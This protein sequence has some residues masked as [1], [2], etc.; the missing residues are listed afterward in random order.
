[1]FLTATKAS[2]STVRSSTPKT[3]KTKTE[4]VVID[5]CNSCDD[6]SQTSQIY[7]LT[8]P[9]KEASPA[10]RDDAEPILIDSRSPSPK[11]KKT[12]SQVRIEMRSCF[13]FDRSTSFLQT[14]LLF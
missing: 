1:V 9:L 3:S 12:D 4:S 13:W 2:K 7:D 14:V 10:A 6:K 8:S 5:L 11:S